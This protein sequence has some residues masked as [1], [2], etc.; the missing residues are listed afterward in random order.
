MKI[1]KLRINAD[2]EAD[3]REFAELLTAIPEVARTGGMTVRENYR[4]EG[5]RGYLTV[6]VDDKENASDKRN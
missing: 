1:I 5:F 4:D 3:L 2:T 6:I